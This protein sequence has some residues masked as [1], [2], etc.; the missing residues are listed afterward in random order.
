MVSFV[1]PTKSPCDLYLRVSNSPNTS[2]FLAIITPKKKGKAECSITFNKPLLYILF[3][4]V[5]P[6][7]AFFNFRREMTKVEILQNT[8]SHD[9]TS[10]IPLSI[11]NLA[12]PNLLY[13]EQTILQLCLPLLVCPSNESEA[14]VDLVLIETSLLFLL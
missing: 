9:T 3:H 6:F 11:S 8:R 12:P 1:C 14:G 13:S 10:S 2:G 5:H 7:N 4:S